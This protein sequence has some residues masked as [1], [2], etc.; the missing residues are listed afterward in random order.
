MTHAALMIYL[1][2]AVFAVAVI[3]NVML[4]YE[5][6]PRTWRQMLSVAIFAGLMCYQVIQWPIW[7]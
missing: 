2:T 1:Q 5:T 4:A 7:S 6:S 3:L